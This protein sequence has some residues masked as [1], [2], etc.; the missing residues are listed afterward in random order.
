VRVPKWQKFAPPR[1][2][3]TAINDIAAIFYKLIASALWHAIQA[4]LRTHFYESHPIGQPNTW[5]E[6]N[7]V[8]ITNYGGINKAYLSCIII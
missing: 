4:Y 6:L 8:S 3:P 2:V 7:R 1:P 5:K